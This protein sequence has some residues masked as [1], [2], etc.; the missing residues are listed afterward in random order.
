MVFKRS[1]IDRG[2]MFQ[3]YKLDRRYQLSVITNLN[4]EL[5]FFNFINLCYKAAIR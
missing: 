1:G 4:K 5:K 3:L 2:I